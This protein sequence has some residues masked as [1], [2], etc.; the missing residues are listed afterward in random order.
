VQP[1]PESRALQS[2]VRG[3][4]RGGQ[5]VLERDWDKLAHEGFPLIETMPGDRKHLLVTF[6]WRPTRPVDRPSIFTP[7]ADFT[8]HQIELESLPGTGIWYRSFQLSRRTRASYG[9]SPLPF[10]DMRGGPKD[11]TRYVRSVVPDPFNADHIVFEKD[12]YTPNDSSQ[13]LSIVELPG[14]PKQ[15]WIRPRGPS[16]WKEGHF[17]VRSKILRNERSV[18]VYLPPNFRPRRIRYNLLV[19]FD[20]FT[21]RSAVP[22]PRIVENLVAAGRIGPTAVLLIGGSQTPRWKELGLDPAF[23]E[24]LARELLPWLRRRYRFTPSGSRTILAGS[25]LGGL[26]SAFA[27]LR[28]PQHFGNVLAMSGAF[29]WARPGD[30]QAPEAL[31]R[32]YVHS[33]TLPIRF[34]LDS[35]TLETTVFP[36]STLSSLASVRHMRDVLEARGY[37]VTYSE[38]EGGHD[39]VC[40]RGTIADGLIHLLGRT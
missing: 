22:T 8:K 4:R 36:G 26:V 28:Y 1:R 38:F 7:V 39:Y 37:S 35:G 23:V 17:R 27:A 21:F 16:E 5:Q 18:W 31:I 2:I 10:P 34:Y 20:G 32:D 40:W 25:S 30:D 33:P 19:V 6:L 15:T 12:P 11:W 3:F 9:F 29:E 13:T 24:F 14:A